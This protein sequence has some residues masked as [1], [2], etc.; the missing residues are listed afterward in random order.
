VWPCKVRIDPLGIA[1][2]SR[3]AASAAP[4][5]TLYRVISLAYLPKKVKRKIGTQAA[6]HHL[7]ESCLVKVRRRTRPMVCF[8]NAASVDRIIFSIFNRFYPQRQNPT[9][10][11]LYTN[12][13]TSPQ[14]P[15]CVEPTS[16][17]VY[18]PR[19]P[20]MVFGQSGRERRA[21]CTSSLRRLTMW[22]PSGTATRLLNTASRVRQGGLETT[23]NRRGMGRRWQN[24]E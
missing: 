5:R 23:K 2:R 15:T 3:W 8:V 18:T 9:L 20:R 17:W 11:L 22:R 24:H 10:R 21:V 16:T 4:G 12:S 14:F 1:T 6:R 19:L 7:S 13:L